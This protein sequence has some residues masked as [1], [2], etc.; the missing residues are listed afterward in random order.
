MKVGLIDFDGKIPNYALMKLSTYYKKQGAGVILNEVPANVDRVY[1]SVLYTWNKAE[2]MK[3][4]SM[5]KNIE[6][7]GTGW[8]YKKELP[9]EVKKCEPDYSLYEI[10]DIYP[11]IRGIMKKETRLK[12]AKTLQKMGLGYTSRGCVRN[13]EFCVVPKKEGRFN[14]TAEIKDLINPK[15]NVITLLDNNFTAD[16]YM[17][18]KCKEIK[19]RGLTVDISQG[20][21][22]RLL[23]D[24]QAKA[25]SEI[26]HL[27]SVHYAWDLMKHE[28]QVMKGIK[29]LTNH[30]KKYKQMCFMLVGFN[31]TFEEDM[32]R[33]KKLVALKVDPYVMIYNKKYNTR[34]KHFA[35]WVNGRIY[36]NAIGRNMSPGL[37]LGKN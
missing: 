2:A 35:R 14:Q 34:L 18:D 10:D 33:F 28:K 3:L 19:E 4:Q 8:D 6:Y 27:R 23:T 7:G 20:I 32:Y 11:N 25:L 9:Q 5:Y 29:T 30:I 24:K 26:K 36:K 22:V 15:S 17:V 21:D 12:K 13:C 31:T 16:P 37:E 1:C